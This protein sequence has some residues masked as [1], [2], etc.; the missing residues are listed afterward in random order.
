LIDKQVYYTVLCDPQSQDSI[1]HIQGTQ[2]T[3][4][5]VRPYFWASST[6]FPC[7]RL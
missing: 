1:S 4:E 7:I 5:F 3:R 2:A 6:F